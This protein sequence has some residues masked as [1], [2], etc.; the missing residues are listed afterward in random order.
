MKKE[1]EIKEKTETYAEKYYTK[2]DKDHARVLKN[3]AVMARSNK[4]GFTD[5]TR[6]EALRE[7]LKD[8]D[9][10][11]I[12]LET[13]SFWYKGE[14]KKN[15]PIILYSSHM[16]T[17]PNI[18]KC[19]ST[20]SNDGYLKGT[21]DN[22]GT[23][24][25]AAIAMLEGN[26][27]DNCVFA[28]T[29]EEETGKCKGAKSIISYLKELG[30]KDITAIT[31]DVTYEGYDEGNL[32]TIENAIKMPDFLD[33]LTDNLKNITPEDMDSVKEDDMSFTFVRK[34]KKAVSDKL[35]K[36]YISKDFGWMD[37]S[38]VYNDLGIKSF[39]ICL[40]CYG[41][42]HSNS[43]VKVKQPVFEGYVNTLEQM[44]YSLTNTH[45]QLI[46]A[47]KIENRE[48]LRRAK[49]LVE[50]E[51][52][53]KK[54][55]YED[56]KAFYQDHSGQ[57]SLFK[58]SEYISDS[59]YEPTENDLYDMYYGACCEDETINNTIRSNAEY[60]I[61]NGLDKDSYINEMMQELS[62]DLYYQFMAFKDYLAESYDAYMEMV[63]DNELA[64]DGFTDEYEEFDLASESYYNGEKITADDLD[65][66]DYDYDD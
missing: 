57:Y 3:L 25:A 47:K 31:L 46:N 17:V 59:Y 45:E 15:T 18:T 48:F 38:F 52:I 19:S 63:Y 7:L 1:E 33:H 62:P 50:K 55:H 42:M 36:E 30:I 10:K 16:D 12:Y 27:P 21:Y 66:D 64:Q 14:L 49:E 11:E 65:F 29:S 6:I 13:V 9:Y 23:N 60:C 2:I 34:S 40:P 35:P 58:G 22:I 61:Y 56:M 5:I 53:E 28:F 26:L 8:T 39:S 43:G 32:F 4:N 54:K 20:L 37:E 41:E 44:A 24:G 51:K